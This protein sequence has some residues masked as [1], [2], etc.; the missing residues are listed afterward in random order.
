MEAKK[1]LDMEVEYYRL[2]RAVDELKNAFL[3][4]PVPGI[5]NFVRLLEVYLDTM[6]QMTRDGVDVTTEPNMPAFGDV[7][8][9]GYLLSMIWG[10]MLKRRALRLDFFKGLLGPEVRV[11]FIKVPK[12]RKLAI[13]VVE[14]EAI[15][16][17]P[18]QRLDASY[19]LSPDREK[20]PGR[21]GPRG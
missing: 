7:Y 18:G 3:D 15:T 21:K 1:Q 14:S 19:H 5:L 20:D 10:E 8:R 2:K 16:A 12:P 13:G 9:L 17:S 11:A 4:S 6:K